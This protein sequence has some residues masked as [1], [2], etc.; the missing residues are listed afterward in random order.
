MSPLQIVHLESSAAD[1]AIVRAELAR[2]GIECNITRVAD[3]GILSKRS[4]PAISI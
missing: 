2:N 3:G 4:P 1:A